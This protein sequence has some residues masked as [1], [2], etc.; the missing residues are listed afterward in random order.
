VDTPYL[1]RTAGAT[2]LVGVDPRFVST[3]PPNAHLQATSP[4]I[5]AGDNAFVVASESD[6]DSKPRVLGL[7]V[8]I[9]AYE[10]GTPA[11]YTFADAL[12][13]IRI[14]AGLTNPTLLDCVRLNVA[15][16]GISFGRVDVADALLIARKVRGLAPNP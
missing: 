6:Y 5:D 2:D 8:D 4:A 11:A 3:E 1:N 12:K 15:N 14:A 16:S 7:R 10:A 13:A 9:G